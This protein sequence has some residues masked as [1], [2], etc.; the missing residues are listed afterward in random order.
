MVFSDLFVSIMQIVTKPYFLVPMLILLIV[1]GA[2]TVVNSWAL[3]RPFT[4]FVLYY[5]SVPT[6]NL[7]G[8][9][10]ANYPI[11]LT[12]MFVM[13]A[14]LSVIGM[15]GMLAIVRLAKGE[16][17]VEAINDSVK[18]WKKALAITII[19]WAAFLIGGVVFSAITMIGDLNLLLGQILALIFF[20]IV[21]V[22]IIKS[23][24][25]IPALS[26]KEAKK[27][28]QESW[29]FTNKRFWGTVLIIILALL[30]AFIGNFAITQLGILLGGLLEL[31]LAI[32]GEA[33]GTTYFI[34]AITNYFYQK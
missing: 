10:L 11:E 34:V 1:S 2:A 3:E 4:D 16:K 13:G 14:V 21:F 12:V 5:D 33:F 24:F 29:K 6:D 27:A 17:I 31:P 18:D 28:I 25:A 20:I 15:M 22:I 19:F 32:I 30:I 26:D 8:V 7:V 9:M 23:V